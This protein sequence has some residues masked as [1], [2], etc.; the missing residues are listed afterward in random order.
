[1]EVSSGVCRLY[2]YHVY[3]ADSAGQ[4]SQI[5]VCRLVGSAWDDLEMETETRRCRFGGKGGPGGAGFIEERGG[6]RGEKARGEEGEGEREK[7]VKGRK[8]SEVE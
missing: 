6:K 8:G 7:S 3:T 1:M 4:C 5:P 2:L